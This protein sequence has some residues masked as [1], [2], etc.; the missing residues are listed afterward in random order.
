M[1]INDAEKNLLFNLVHTKVQTLKSLIREW[2]ALPDDA[3]VNNL[4]RF[5][6]AKAQEE[7]PKF[8]ALL[9][10]IRNGDPIP[11]IVPATDLDED[12]VYSVRTLLY[13]V[14]TAKK[15]IDT[16][17]ERLLFIPESLSNQVAHLLSPMI[18]ELAEIE[19]IIVGACPDITKEEVDE[20]DT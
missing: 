11:E 15:L 3:I 12:S 17:H 8:E 9:S 19:S 10:H 1:R 5:G 16:G 6:V 7:L 2:D 14:G 4:E 20:S 13:E 18:R